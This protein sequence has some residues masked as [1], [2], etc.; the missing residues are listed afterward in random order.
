MAD[1]PPL[2]G[3]DPAS[4]PDPRIFGASGKPERAG[5]P[6]AAWAAA[7]LIVLL[8]VVA[9]VFAGKKSPP[10]PSTLQPEDPYAASLPLS[11]LAM[12]ESESL[13]GTKVTYLDG[14]IQNAGP[15]TVAAVTVQVVFANDEAMPPQIVTQPLTL[16]RTRQPYVDTEP[17]STEPL[18]PGDDREFRLIFE[19]VPRNWNTQMPQ[20]RIIR[21][22]L[23]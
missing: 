6:P 13:S 17:V 14:R 18:K 9:L 7:A 4:R 22:D 19:A 21:T 5:L 23:R 12:S 2:S 3:A 15:R 11:G 1:L 8:V 20:V 10:P 16:I